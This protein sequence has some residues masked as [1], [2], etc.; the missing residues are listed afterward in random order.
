MRF[1]CILA[2]FLV[3]AAA[4]AASMVGAV[5]L[6][7][8]IK[9]AVPGIKPPVI[10]NCPDLN[11]EWSDCG[12]ACPAVCGSDDPLV[13]NTKCVKG[14]FCREG[15]RLESDEK[16]AKCVA[17]RA[18]APP[19]ETPV[20]GIITT[21]VATTTTGTCTAGSD[22]CHA[23]GILN[24]HLQCVKCKNERLLSN[25]VCITKEAC[26]LL[27]GVS[28]GKGKRGRA[29]ATNNFGEDGQPGNNR[30]SDLTT[31]WIYKG[32][33][34]KDCNWVGKKPEKRCKLKH[35]GDRGKKARNECKAACGTC[36]G[37]Q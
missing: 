14:C 16:G 12:T 30:C 25:G 19:M 7:N 18:C 21:T 3:A 13:C 23:C 6:P 27:G 29:C 4:A 10:H 1:T 15:F 36:P 20:P 26:A 32:N 34:R 24:L 17:D 28:E 35:L 37:R 11:A 22:N 33:S 31:S 9:P 5:P 8:P 2:A